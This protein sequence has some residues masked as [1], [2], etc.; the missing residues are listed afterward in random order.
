M[1]PLRS[2]Q[3]GFGVLPD[4]ILFHGPTLHAPNTLT[5]GKPTTLAVPTSVMLLP[6]SQ[7]LQIIQGKRVAAECALRR[8]V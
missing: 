3:S 7:A 5:H 8:T 6:H 2:F 4:Q 1:Y